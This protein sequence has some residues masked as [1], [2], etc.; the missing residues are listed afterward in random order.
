[1]RALGISL[2]TV[3]VAFSA[4]SHQTSAYS[5]TAHFGTAAFTN[6]VSGGYTLDLNPYPDVSLL[7]MNR[8]AGHA[9]GRIYLSPTGFTIGESGNYWVSIMAVVYNPDESLSKVTV[10]IVL[11]RNEEIDLENFESL[12]GATTIE[13]GSAGQITGEGTLMNV[14]EG[15]RFSIVAGTGGEDPASVLVLSWQISVQRIPD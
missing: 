10:P 12:G 8:N 1:M 4:L 14:M 6:A 11:A 3:T 7:S 2:L 15:E 5:K 9:G 13:P